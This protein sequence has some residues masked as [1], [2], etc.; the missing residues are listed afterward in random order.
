MS[1]AT[2][3]Q[4]ARLFIFILGGGAQQAGGAPPGAD[5]RHGAG[6]VL[7]VSTKLPLP[8][9]GHRAWRGPHPGGRL[10][11]PPRACWAPPPQI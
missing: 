6:E 9:P 5:D 11:A 7:Y 8:R 1:S 4:Q 10:A 3:G 2:Q